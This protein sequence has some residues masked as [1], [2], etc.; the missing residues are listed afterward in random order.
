M[1]TKQHAH[2]I[3]PQGGFEVNEVAINLVMM[4]VYALLNM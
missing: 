1:Q 3:I 2:I 4:H